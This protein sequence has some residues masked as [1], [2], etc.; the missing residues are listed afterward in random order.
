MAISVGDK[1]PIFS[2]PNQRGEIFKISEFIGKKLLVIY[3]YPKDE[4]TGCTAEACSFRDSYEE[5]ESMG[6]EI[7][8]ISSDSISSHEKF[9]SKYR[10]NFT[11]LADT[12]QTVRRKFGVPTNFFGLVAGR[13]TYIVDISGI[14]RSVH[15]AQ[16]DATSHIKESI[17]MIKKLSTV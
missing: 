15:N 10:L 16:V 3:F 11:L 9:A 17:K 2:L 4:T 14:V 8:G 6:C 1:C 7:I 12:E 13:V 5:F